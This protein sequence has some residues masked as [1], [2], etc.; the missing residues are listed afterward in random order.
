MPRAFWDFVGL[1]DLVRAETGQFLKWCHRIP[2]LRIPQRSHRHHGA[3]D[4]N[5]VYDVERDPGQTR[6]LRDMALE[7]R[8]AI[9]MRELLIEVDAPE[10]QFDRMGFDRP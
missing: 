5:P 4:S 1:E 8:L 10:C 6:P 7:E 9:Q 2:H 3:G